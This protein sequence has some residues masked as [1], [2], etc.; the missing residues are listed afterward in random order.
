MTLFCL[1]FVPLFF[2]EE[3][4][5]DDDVVEPVAE[6][7]SK[8]IQDVP[9][10]EGSGK[11][12]DVAMGATETKT[13]ISEQEISGG[14]EPNIGAGDAPSQIEEQ[15]VETK[16]AD[17]NAGTSVCIFPVSQKE[18]NFLCDN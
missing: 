14:T 3:D 8:I 6:K 5:D 17:N 18:T 11:S 15:I 13:E 7:A 16:S 12:D 9:A 4:D 1:F 2:I 10:I